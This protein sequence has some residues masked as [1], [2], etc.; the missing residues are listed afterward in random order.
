MNQNWKMEEWV[1]DKERQALEQ[2]RE[3]KMTEG[4]RI[5]FIKQAHV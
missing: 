3:D 1:I 2:T 4:G 5:F